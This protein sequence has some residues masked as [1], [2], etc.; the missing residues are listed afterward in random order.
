MRI[1]MFK[2]LGYPVPL[3]MLRAKVLK[4]LKP[5]GNRIMVAQETEHEPEKVEVFDV[6]QIYPRFAVLTDKHGTREAFLYQDLYK[7]MR[8]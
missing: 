4:R 5:F 1:P 6:F 3:E 8:R 7:H 2:P